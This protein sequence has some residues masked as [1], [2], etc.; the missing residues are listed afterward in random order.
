VPVLPPHL[1][2]L[3]LPQQHYSSIARR[4]R[5]CQQGHPRLLRSP[6]PLSLVTGYAS[7]YHVVPRLPSSPR[8]GY[9]VIKGELSFGR[10]CSAVLTG[11]LIPCQDCTPGQR[12]EQP[13]RDAHKV[14]E[15]NHQRH[16]QS[17]IL[18]PDPGLCC[19]NDLSFLLEHQYD[20]S[21]NR[22]DVQRLK[23]GVKNQNA[24]REPTLPHGERSHLLDAKSG[25]S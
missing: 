20:G 6:I 1:V 9:N 16:V 15:P 23:G 14:H 17:Q 10:L 22:D 24:A 25:R 21:T 11:V 19:L 13:M 4:R 3:H 7:R 5:S 18:R 8:A 2:A 12:H